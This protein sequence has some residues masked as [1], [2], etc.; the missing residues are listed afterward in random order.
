MAEE[1]EK[2]EVDSEAADAVKQKPPARKAGKKAPKKKP[3]KK[4]AGERKKAPK[5]QPEAD[6]ENAP[7]P[8][9]AKLAHERD[10]FAVARR[11]VR[12]AVPA[13]VDK[14]VEKASEGSCA[15]ARTLLDLTGARHMFDN[16]PEAAEP[17]ESWARLV[18][19]RLDEAEAEGKA[20]E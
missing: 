13:I 16:Q 15:H 4:K 19:E 2:A 14:L 20:A 17:G 3:A 12:A 5:K 6:A 1:R 10:P 11:K 7:A 8:P 9:K 18:I